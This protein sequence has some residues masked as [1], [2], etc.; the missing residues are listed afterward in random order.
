[1]W[2]CVKK[3]H[4]DK[5][6]Q[7]LLSIQNPHLIKVQTFNLILL[8]YFIN[9][10]FYSLYQIICYK[11]M[12]CKP[13]FPLFRITKD[14]IFFVFLASYKEMTQEVKAFL[15]SECCMEQIDWKGHQQTFLY[16][17]KKEMK[18]YNLRIKKN[19]LKR[20]FNQGIFFE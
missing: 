5:V 13:M 17:L 18:N 19:S 3:I 12:H 15:H 6:Q 2:K 7:N 8:K 4:A 16:I 11:K 1:M 10:S 9:V 20:I 14:F